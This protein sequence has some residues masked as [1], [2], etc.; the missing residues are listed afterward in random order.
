LELVAF[1]SLT[2]GANRADDPRSTTKQA[3]TQRFESKLVWESLCVIGLFVGVALGTGYAL[4]YLNGAPFIDSLFESSSALSTTGLTVGI[5]SMDLD[6][7]S[8]SIL[9]ANMI[10]G[11][12]EI[13]LVLYIISSA[14]RRKLR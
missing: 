3:A 13:I 5:T 2:R 1:G 8:K 4:S 9:I 6:L 12:F 10:F 14:V 11:K 7:A